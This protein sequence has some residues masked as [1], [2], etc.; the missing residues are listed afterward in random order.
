MTDKMVI[1]FSYKPDGDIFLMVYT[2]VEF[3]IIV[4]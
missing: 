2:H 4:P 1:F 3:I